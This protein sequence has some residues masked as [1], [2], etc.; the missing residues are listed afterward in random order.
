MFKKLPVL[1][2]KDEKKQLRLLRL[3]GDAQESVSHPWIRPGLWVSALTVL[4]FVVWASWAE[5]DEVTRGEGRVIP[6]SRLQKIQSLEGGILDEL[7]VKEGDMVEAGQALVSLDQT[8]FYAAY[9]EGQSKARTLRAAIARLEAEVKDKSSIDFPDSLPL[10]GPEVSSERSLFEARRSKKEQAISSLQEEVE[11]TSEELRL[12]EPLV[13]TNAVSEVEALRL[14]QEIATLKGRIAEIE[15]G[16]IQEAYTEL[17]AKKAELASLE[18]TLL[19]KE[20]QLR[21]TKLVSPVKGMVNNILVTTRGGVVQPGEAI[22]EV[23][24]IE[25][26]LLVQTKIK[27]ED[28]AFIAPG[29]PAKVKITAYDYTIYGDL[30]GTVVQIS[31][32]TI[33]EETVRGKEYFYQVLVRTEKNYLEKHDE[34]LPIR[35][36]MIAEVDILGGKRKIMSYILKPLLKARLY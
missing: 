17:T 14:K 28:V 22:M 30:A 23:L 33:E 8:R 26:Q 18:Q 10:D 11:L 29:M 3:L 7:L 21:R 6:Y 2:T 35:P 15:N 24:P 34:M 9:M 36:G 12:I 25:D 1:K 27:P 19:Q 5:I 4:I 32:D 20:D 13:A 16:F 31:A